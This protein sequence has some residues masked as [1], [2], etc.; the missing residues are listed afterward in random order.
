MELVSIATGSET[1]D[2]V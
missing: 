1:V 2:L